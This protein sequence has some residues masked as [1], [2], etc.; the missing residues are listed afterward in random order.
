MIR[1]AFKEVKNI[2]T[3]V[4]AEKLKRIFRLFKI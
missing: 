1:I 4:K 2:F 3:V